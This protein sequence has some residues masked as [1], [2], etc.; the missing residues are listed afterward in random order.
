MSGATWTKFFWSDWDTDPAL[1]ACSFAAQGFWMRLLCI[2][3]AHDPIGY[4]AVAGRSLT[5]TDIARMTGGSESEVSALL[6]ELD[7]NGVFSRDR[8]GR[9]YSRRMVLDARKAAIAK[10]NGKL[11]GNPSLGKHGKIPKSVNHPDKSGLK[12]QEPEARSQEVIVPFPEPPEIDQPQQNGRA[13][14][15]GSRLPPDWDGEGEAVTHAIRAG[16]NDL[17]A[18]QMLDD[19]RDFWTAKAGADACKLDWLA[20]WRRWVREE[21]KRRSR[22]QTGPPKRVGWV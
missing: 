20:T 18:F 3:A 15:R 2:A 5:E 19:F 6:G 1:R 4:V 13:V 11:G 16:F 10:K 9:I 17:E 7:R 8:H 21:G 12:T 22:R 14:P